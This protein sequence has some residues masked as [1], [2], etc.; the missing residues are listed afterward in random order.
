MGVKFIL[1]VDRDKIWKKDLKENFLNI[2]PT[3]GVL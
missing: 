3:E 1:T 2:L